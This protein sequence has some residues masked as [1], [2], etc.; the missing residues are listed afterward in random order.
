MAA[1]N[2]NLNIEKGVNFSISMVLQRANGDY[3]DLSDSGVCVTAEIVEFYGLPAI[4][5]FSITE[6]LPSGVTLSLNSTGTL[7]LPFFNSYY[8]VV[9]NTNGIKERLV[10]GEIITSENATQNTSCQ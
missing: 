9:L 4:T 1:A 8:D 6:N 7:A 5:G 10:Q 2:Y 3:V